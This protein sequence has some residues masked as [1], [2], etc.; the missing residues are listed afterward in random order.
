VK[1][2]VECVPNFSEGRKPEVIARL[3]EA[4][5]D[6]REAR[7]AVLGAHADPDHHRAVITFAGE[8]EAMID[9]AVEVAARAR[10]LIDLRAHRG[11]H[12]RLGA[13][14][15]MP[16]V[17]VSG[18][19]MDECVNLA[20]RAGARIA[21]ELNLPVYFY[22]RAALRPDRRRLESVRRGGFE[23]LREEVGVAAES[24]P[25]LGPPRLHES[26]GAVIVGAR[27]FLIAYNVNLRTND[28]DAAR[29]IAGR[30]RARDGGL[31]DLKALGLFLAT[32]ELA[33][34]SMNLINYEVT[35]MEQAYQAVEREAQNLGV[36]IESSEIVGLV[37]RAAL[38]PDAAARLK[39]E[40]FSPNLI[41]EDRMNKI[42][43]I[44]NR[45]P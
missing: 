29:R 26:A 44:K 9:A 36:E 25:D 22:E 5:E 1:T 6:G 38:P 37:P 21:N 19:T 39:I 20:H 42:F 10:E 15:V 27:P 7:V 35:S 11:V 40:N 30:V 18:L 16:F 4:V 2:I 28:V 8:P 45:L 24:A 23:Q 12:P 14:D 41:L 43:M 13:I 17:P 31:P 34:V 33:Q 3:I 32:R